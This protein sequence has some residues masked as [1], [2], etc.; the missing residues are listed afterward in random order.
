MK[1]SE[2]AEIVS[3]IKV[4]IAACNPTVEQVSA[5]LTQ[6]EYNGIFVNFYNFYG[7]I[8]KTGTKTLSSREDGVKKIFVNCPLGA[9]VVKINVRDRGT[10]GDGNFGKYVGYDPE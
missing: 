3:E 1:R 5:G 6:Q 7:E 8:R 2:L 10:H 4:A 9:G